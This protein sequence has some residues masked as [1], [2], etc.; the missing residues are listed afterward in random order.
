MFE[1]EWERAEGSLK[2][3]IARDPSFTWAY[4]MYAVLLKREGRFD[5]AIEQLHRAKRIDPAATPPANIDL[6]L[7]YVL[8]GDLERA[9]AAWQE[10]LELHPDDY[11]IHRQLAVYAC[12]TGDFEEGFRQLERVAALAHDAER[13]LSDLGYCHAL[14]GQ[15]EKAE[16]ALAKLGKA[17]EGLYIDPVHFA[18]IHMALGDSERAFELLERA[19]EIN[20]SLLGEVP[21]DPRYD[22]IRSDP[23][24]TEIVTGMGLEHL[25]PPPKG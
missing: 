7:L 14:A 5:E 10:S 25:L 15:R 13:L 21:T 16:E 2:R 20:A 12:R 8:K 9:A 1:W 18:L 17:A 4:Q 22:S 11:G 23:R 3:A 24:Y 19:L 6:G